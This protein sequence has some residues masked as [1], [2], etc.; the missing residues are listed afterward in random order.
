MEGK[1]AFITGGSSGYGKAT[2][3]K[4]VESGATV[5]IAARNREQLEHAQA[6]IGCASVICMDV[7]KYVDWQRAYATIVEQY[8]RLD[9]LVNNA[10][11]GVA[12]KSIVDQTQDEIDRSIALNLTSA[13]YGTQVFAPLMKEQKEGTIINV[14]SVCAKQAWP[15]FSIYGAAKTGMLGFSKG[16]YV[17]LRPYNIRVTCVIPASASTGFEK[18][19]NLIPSPH[20]LTVGDVADSILYV[21]NLPQ[22]AAVEEL[23]V[24]GMDQ[25]VIPL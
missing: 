17:D 5:I 6:E 22:H 25:E 13:I 19:A 4:M 18:S 15:G 24:W 20:A 1:I 16:A 14:A 23:T 8:G 9:I 3:A 2:A 10:G 7:T 21:C 12:I 11:A